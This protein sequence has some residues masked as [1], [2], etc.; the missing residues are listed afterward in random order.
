METTVYVQEDQ[1]GLISEP[2][3]WCAKVREL[4]LSGQE[5]IVADGKAANP[6]L[7]LDVGLLRIFETL[8]PTKEEIEKFSAEP[9]PMEALGAYGLAV[10]EKYFE[11]VEVWYSPGQ[12][13]PVM[14]G[15][16][17]REHFLMAQWGPEKRD[18]TQ[19]RVLAREKWIALAR[20]KLH[21]AIGEARLN[22]ENIETKADAHF[23]GEWTGIY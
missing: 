10:R 4:G 5:S 12:H 1:L 6:F 14:I 21:G 19:C 8:C 22:L 3:A 18:I 20:N 7:R 17:K 9:I 11:K 15:S 23:A 2:E 16:T 13:D